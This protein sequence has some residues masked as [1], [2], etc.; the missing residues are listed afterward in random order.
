MKSSANIGKQ[1][2]KVLVN[3]QLKNK[4]YPPLSKCSIEQL[5]ELRTY[6]RKVSKK[7]LIIIVKELESR[8]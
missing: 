1:K 7:A 8:L 3:Y 5:R 4:G 2:G 6:Y